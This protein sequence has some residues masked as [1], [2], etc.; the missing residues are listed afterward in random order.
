MAIGLSS[1]KF[2][3]NQ[4]FAKNNIFVFYF[5]LINRRDNYLIF[6]ALNKIVVEKVFAN[7]QHK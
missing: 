1:I 6:R 7:D 2:L 3:D 5:T 4:K